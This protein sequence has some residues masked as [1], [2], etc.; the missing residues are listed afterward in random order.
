MKIYKYFC[1][2][3]HA[4]RSLFFHEKNPIY[5][6]IACRLWHRQSCCF[7]WHVYVQQRNTAK[8]CRRVFFYYKHYIT[9]AR[10]LRKKRGH[11][12]FRFPNIQSD[13]ALQLIILLSY[14]TFKSNSLFFIVNTILSKIRGYLCAK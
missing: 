14:T 7:K 12:I 9:I 2:H 13:L 3:Y 1:A 4:L 8:K 5:S 10:R 11:R 6:T